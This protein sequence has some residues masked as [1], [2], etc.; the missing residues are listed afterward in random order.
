MN[1]IDKIELGGIVSI[2]DRLL[3]QQAKGRDIYRLESGD[4]SFDVPP[5]IIEAIKKALHDGHTHYTAGAGIK[6][7]REA[8][9]EKVVTKNH[10]PITSPESIL[11]TNGAMHGLYIVFR[12]LIEPGEDVCVPDPTWTETADNVGLAGGYAARITLD[13]D[14]T[15]S[16]DALRKMINPR[17]K[18]IV[19]NSPHN[20]TGKVYNQK[21]LQEIIDIASAR[22]LWIISD[23]AY[24]HIVFDGNKH[25]SLG[26][27]G[28]DRVISVYSMSKSY[29]M[30]GLRLGYVV[31]ENKQYRERMQKLLRCTINGVNSATQYGG[32]AALRGS[33]EYIDSMV[34]VYNLRRNIL[35]DG[36]SNVKTLKPIKPEGA[37]YLWAKILDNRDAWD[38]TNHLIDSIGVGSTPGDVFGPA[39]KGWLRFSFSCPTDQIQ[40]AVKLLQTAL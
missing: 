30:S 21:V 37:F 9:F 23:E 8:A 32:V 29:A 40:D 34:D 10:L 25:I 20:P 14:L 13:S 31:V 15:L 24:E 35:F 26:S 1:S 22:G 36:L 38:I 6:Q 27:F 33:N 3:E 17:T 18:A 28:Y 39:G 16:R 19:I 7:L 2:R 11:I 5:H 12:A 4:P